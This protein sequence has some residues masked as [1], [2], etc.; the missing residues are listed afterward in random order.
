MPVICYV[1]KADDAISIFAWSLYHLDASF[2]IDQGETH[3]ARF[4][5]A[6]VADYELALMIH[7][8]NL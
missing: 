8:A 7:Y 6:Q 5:P 1:Y 4:V 2:H 3:N